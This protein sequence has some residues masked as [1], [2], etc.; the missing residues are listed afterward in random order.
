VV[1]RA[2]TAAGSSCDLLLIGEPLRTGAAR[3]LR[4]G[5]RASCLL[6]LRPAGD[7]WTVVG[8]LARALQAHTGAAGVG[9]A[10]VAAADIGAWLG[11]LVTGLA[12]DLP[13]DV[14]LRLAAI[15]TDAPPPLLRADAVLL[16][17]TR[18]SRMAERLEAAEQQ[19]AAME[20]GPVRGEARGEAPRG[21]R[22]DGELRGASDLA[23]REL[24]LRE[25]AATEPEPP[26][27]LQSRV[28]TAGGEPLDT[29]LAP[30]TDYR[31]AVRVGP[32]ERGWTA[33]TGTAFPRLDGAGPH[34]LTVVLTIPGI[35]A[36][37]AVDAIVLPARGPSTTCSFHVH[38]P[39]GCERLWGRII[40]LHG[41]RVLQ[42]A[43]LDVRIGA[44]GQTLDAEPEA[45]VRLRL[46]DLDSRRAFDAA[47]LVNH[48]EA[49]TPGLTTVAG[50]RAAVVLPVDFSRAVS[51][52]RDI[53]EDAV[54][55]PSGF[56]GLDDD[57]SVSLLRALANHGSELHRVFMAS[58]GAQSVVDGDRLQLVALRQGADFPLEFV[59]ERAAPSPHASLCPASGD[60]L[61]VGSCG[62][63]CAAPDDSEV[64]CPLAFWGLSKSIERI[65]Y[66]QQIGDHDLE[67]RAEP[68]R[69]HSRLSAP[70][71]VL[72]A[73]SSRVA[74]DD[75]KALGRALER[76][77]E[78]SARQVTSWEQWCKRVETEHTAMLVL[79]PHT[80]IHPEFRLPAMEI[81]DDAPLAHTNVGKAHVCPT[82]AHRPLVILLGCNT[83]A[84]PVPIHDF[85]SKFQSGGAAIVLGT[86]TEVLGRHAAPVAATIVAEL[87]RRAR[88]GEAYITDVVRDVRR[89]L[90]AEGSPF[91]MT[92]VAYGDGEWTLGGG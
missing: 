8:P 33:D 51:G 67:V 43:T 78:G 12:N 18:L 34:R 87:A 6:V 82:G 84:S 42:T 86:V 7:E 40:V 81:S 5:V 58:A 72:Y 92:L 54:L 1:P 64:V 77:M 23:R 9:F 16:E 24:Q 49:G 15:V 59:Y 71:A 10:P 88:A 76:E 61:T 89:A 35:L 2:V 45:A 57:A 73:A 19:R 13:L 21:L 31:I 26:R 63:G 38:V 44:A 48:D 37:P 30:D 3:V 4:S 62:V 60:R 75:V 66:K 79:L 65:P 36:E 28:L 25:A 83:A 53:L 69:D 47:L 70:G 74:D 20:R 32:P 56:A 80:L 46:D 22:F 11:A 14:A 52:V 50:D 39:P 29:A 85:P 55:E 17:E 91:G 90:L 41:N 68:T 27:F